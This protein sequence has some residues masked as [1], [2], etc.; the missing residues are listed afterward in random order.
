M[1]NIGVFDSGLGGL[2]VFD[3]LQKKIK[4]NYF[5]YADQRFAPYGP[6]SQIDLIERCHEVT[7]ELL[8]QKVD[9][10]V[11]ACNSA[12]AQA[13]KT[14]REN[15]KIPFVG[16]EPYIK[17]NQNLNEIKNLKTAALMTLATHQS[18][19]FKELVEL[20][21]PNQ[22]IFSC[23]CLNLAK[24]IEDFLTDD[25][26][27]KEFQNIV[28][29]ELKVLEKEKIDSVILG[30]THYNFL[31]DW[32]RDFFQLRVFDNRMSIVNRVESLIGTQIPGPIDR[33]QFFSSR[34]EVWREKKISMIEN[35]WYKMRQA[36]PGEIHDK[37]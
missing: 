19:K 18:E 17:I 3:S 5:Y 15:Y 27:V 21:D 22:N 33:F 8:K 4:A 30:C 35:F 13:I 2:S 20:F 9:I 36:I 24:A 6:K 28:C 32:F 23:V 16:I 26:D 1:K 10:I 25:L 29:L 12:T 31:I 11:V 7:K 14:L 34:D 37:N